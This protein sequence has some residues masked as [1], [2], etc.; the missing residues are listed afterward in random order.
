MD[1]KKLPQKN[2]AKNNKYNYQNKKSQLIQQVWSL[3]SVAK[4]FPLPPCFC[5]KLIS[6]TTL[7]C[8]KHNL[9]SKTPKTET[10]ETLNGKTKT[11]NTLNK[12]P[13][14]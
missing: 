5:R 13:G 4:G 14:N 9:H 7:F 6:T 2:S 8:R 1:Q 3:K 12:I 10:G 11:E